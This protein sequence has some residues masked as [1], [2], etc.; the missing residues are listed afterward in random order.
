MFTAKCQ[1]KM[2]A[3]VWKDIPDFD[4]YEVSDLG[5]V[6]NKKSQRVMIKFQSDS[7][8]QRITLRCNKKYVTR[9]VH[10]LVALAFLPNPEGKA[11]VN[12]KNR[13]KND[14][15]LENLEWAS[16]SEQSLHVRQE[17]YSD[18]FSGSSY[19][20]NISDDEIW[21]PT[22]NAM[23]EVSD[24]GAIRNVT[25]G[26][27]K[28]IRIDGRGYCAT[29]LGTVHR[30]VAQA[31]LPNF[32]EA[33]VVNHKDGNKSNNNV[34][35][36]E[37]ITQS[38]NV[39]HGYATNIRK[40][41][42]TVHVLQVDYHGIIVGSYQSLAEAE[43][44]SGFNR[45]GIH[46]SIHG[47]NASNG[48]MWYTSLEDYE[49]DRPNISSKI[50]KVFQYTQAGDLIGTYNDFRVAEEKTG[51]PHGNI[52]STVNAFKHRLR[53]AGGYI[54]TTSRVPKTELLEELRHNALVLNKG[55]DEKN[56]KMRKADGATIIKVLK[57]H[58]ENPKM[59]QEELGAE[60]GVS[61]QYISRI[62]HGKGTVMKE[63]EFPC[64]GVTWDQYN[65]MLV[66]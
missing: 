19:I 40:I 22:T 38:L 56:I 5:N 29:K 13:V 31:F 20:P 8:Y 24:K 63:C 49:K 65:A 11:T 55:L 28:T 47:G 3:E 17:V 33:C 39:L 9:D 30:M 1:R 6:R 2:A 58:H 32:T 64:E 54:W 36:L 7:G 23:F 46:D 12:H 10:R 57:K 27:L 60:F 50:F 59:T 37:C 66:V 41:R 44:A 34:S 51:V 26:R 62:L 61:R 43:A 25:N 14:N 18:Q 35:N 15:R 4:Q 16:Y 42:K 52:S 48:Y 45:G 53:S 21:K